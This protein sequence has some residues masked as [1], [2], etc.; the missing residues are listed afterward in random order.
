MP[1][2]L[3]LACWAAV[4][5]AEPLPQPHAPGIESP[6]YVWN[7]PNEEQLRA[8]AHEADPVN[9]E[10]AYAVC[11]GCHRADGAGRGDALYPQL[12]GQHAT[13]LIKQMVDVRTGRRDNPKMHPFVAEWVVSTEDVADIAAYL[14]SLPI[15]TNNLKGPGEQLAQGRIL[16]ERDCAICHGGQGEGDAEEFYPRVAGQHYSYLDQESRLIRDRGRRNANPEM[17]KAIAGYSDAEIAAVSDYLSRLP[18]DA[19]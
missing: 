18:T 10:L 4:V 15:P 6:D 8:L 13:V 17:V 19:Q 12:A 3:V 1:S 14:A 9:G 11:R 5:V 2:L 16:Y 7:A